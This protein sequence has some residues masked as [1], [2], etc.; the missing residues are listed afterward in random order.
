MVTDILDLL[1]ELDTDSALANGPDELLDDA[2][3]GNSVT[4]DEMGDG[5]GEID[6]MGAA[7]G[8]VVQDDRPF[9]GITEIERRDA[10]RWELDPASAEDGPL[11]P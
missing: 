11:A 2:A 7:A 10:H 8:L 3:R 9:Q 1:D 6:A 5:S 4:S